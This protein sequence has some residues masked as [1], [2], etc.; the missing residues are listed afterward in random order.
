MNGMGAGIE[1]YTSRR[2]NEETGNRGD[3]VPKEDVRVHVRDC[4]VE[5]RVRWSRVVVM[6]MPGWI[7]VEDF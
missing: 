3:R 1:E 5:G 2:E 6:V 4:N 7:M